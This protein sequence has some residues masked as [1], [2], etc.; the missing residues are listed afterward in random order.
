MNDR[1]QKA[2]DAFFAAHAEDPRRVEIDGREAPWSV[3]YHER[4]LAWLGTLAPDAAEP[5]KLA[6]ACQ[7]IR[8]WTRPREE[9]PKGKLGY[10]KWRRD[11]AEFHGEQAAALLRQAGYDDAVIQRVRDLLLKRNLG[12]DP[13]VQVLED[14]VCL[15]FLENEFATF[16]ARHDEEKIATILRKTWTKMSDRGQEEA[17]LLASRLPAQLQLLMQRALG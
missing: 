3:F 10:K 7:H 8:R 4:M 15:V 11:L 6:A 14:V 16:A 9:Y 12:S 2:V 5:L 1:Y 17:L 13:E